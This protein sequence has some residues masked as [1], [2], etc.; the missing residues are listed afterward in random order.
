M[1]I[2]RKSMNLFSQN[3]AKLKIISSKFRVPRN[4][5]NA[6]SQPPYTLSARRKGCVK[7][8][9]MVLFIFPPGSDPH[10]ICGSR[11][12]RKYFQIKTEN[13]FRKLVITFVLLGVSCIVASFSYYLTFSFSPY[14]YYFMSS[15]NLPQL[16][17]QRR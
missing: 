17:L 8:M 2:S 5:V 4:F 6:V 12:R 11:S 14:Q 15:S 7:K 13:N 9:L 10:S 1:G 3:F 16:F